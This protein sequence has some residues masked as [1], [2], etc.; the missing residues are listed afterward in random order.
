METSNRS[1][2]Y[3]PINKEIPKKISAIGVLGGIT[4]PVKALCLYWPVSGQSVG[5]VGLSVC[6]SVCPDNKVN[7][8]WDRY[9]AQWFT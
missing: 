8:L 9:L 1:F 4:T 7:N 3:V 6:L 5:S 2:V